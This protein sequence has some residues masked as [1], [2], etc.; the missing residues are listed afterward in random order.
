MAITKETWVNRR[1]VGFVVGLALLEVSRV[2]AQPTTTGPAKGALVLVGGGANRAA[3]IQRFVDLAGG[4]GAPI[5][6][7]PTTLEDA[8]LTPDGIAQLRARMADIL[9]AP[10]VTVLHTRDRLVADSPDF[11]EPLR[12]ANGVWILG[13]N[14]EYLMDVYT[15]T[16]TQD[17]VRALLARG[18]V[19][20]GTS[21]GA[22]IQGSA[23]VIGEGPGLTKLLIDQQ[24]V[25]FGLLSN[26]VVIPH[27]SQRSLREVA[28]V[29]LTA[30]PDLFGI[31]IDEATA[32]VIQQ[33]RLEVVGDGHV[34]IY[35]GRTH[36]GKPYVD[37]APGQRFDL[38]TGALLPQ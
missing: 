12:H 37:L 11:V 29:A 9:G 32:A 14:E 24:H 34:G 3:F 10:H 30:R 7:I 4:A 18:G 36:D 28:S 38:W 22:I 15:G 25:P 33:H 31:G 16:R 21:A 26:A 20:G 6:L 1:I 19:V 35:D 23:A 8:R 13:G 17:E 2:A 5:V 27:W